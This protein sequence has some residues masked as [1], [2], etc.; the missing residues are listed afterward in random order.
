M[1]TCYP[2]LKA[3]SHAPVSGEPYSFDVQHSLELGGVFNF[4]G[5]KFSM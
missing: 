2:I 5:P 1:L 3:D 4:P